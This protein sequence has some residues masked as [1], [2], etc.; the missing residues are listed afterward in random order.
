MELLKPE[1]E[2][3]KGAHILTANHNGFV[4]SYHHSSKYNVHRALNK[5]ENSSKFT[6]H[7]RKSCSPFPTY[8]SSSLAVTVKVIPNL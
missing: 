2:I 3:L 6:C 5:A 7:A 1:G 8:F 4:M